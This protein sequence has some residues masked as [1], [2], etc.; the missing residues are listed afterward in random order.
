MA[1]DPVSPARRLTRAG[2]RMAPVCGQLSALQHSLQVPPSPETWVLLEFELSWAPA[3]E[4]ILRASHWSLGLKEYRWNTEV[5]FP[6]Q[7]LIPSNVMSS[8]LACA[9][10]WAHV[11]V[12][13]AW[14][15]SFLHSF[16]KGRIVP[17]NA[18]KQA[19]VLTACLHLGSIFRPCLSY[20]CAFEREVFYTNNSKKLW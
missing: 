11:S 5:N 18:V 10:K 3:A 6:G 7:E 1:G 12:T 17:R 19:C 15:F 9:E 4:A 14:S 20:S 2:P 8:S 13:L 16:C